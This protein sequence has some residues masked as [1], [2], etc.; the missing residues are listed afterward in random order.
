MQTSKLET[1]QGHG[2]IENEMLS[3]IFVKLDPSNCAFVYVPLKGYDL[4]MC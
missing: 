2:V 1:A 3:R 4:N